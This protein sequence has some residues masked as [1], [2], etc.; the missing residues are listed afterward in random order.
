MEEVFWKQKARNSWLQAGDRNTQHFQAS[1]QERIRRENITEIKDNNGV[2]ITEEAQLKAE[3]VLFFSSLFQA[4]PSSSSKVFLTVIPFVLSPWDNSTL[5]APPTLTETFEP[6]VGEDI[7]KAARYFV[8][9]GQ[10]PRAFSVSLISLVPKNQAAASFADYRPI[11]LC[12]VIYKIFSKLLVTRLSKFLPKLISMEQ[13]AFMQ[14]RSIIENVAMALEAMRNIDK[15]TREGNL[16][17]KLDLEKAYDRVDWVFLKKVMRRFGFSARAGEIASFRSFSMGSLQGSSN[18]HGGSARGTP[19]PQG[20]SFLRL[21]SSPGTLSSWWREAG[22]NLSIKTFLE[23]F[24]DVSGQRIN[25]QKSSFFCPAKM[26]T[27]R[28]RQTERVLGFSK[29]RAGVQYLGIPLYKGRVSMASFKAL[30]DKVEGKKK[31]QWV[32][33]SK[34]SRPIEEGGLGVRKLKEVLKALRRKMA[35]NVKYGQKDSPWVLYIRARHRLDLEEGRTATSSSSASPYWKEVRTELPMLANS[36]Q[37]NVGNGE[38]NVWSTNWTGLGPLQSMVTTHIPQELMSL[39]VKD[40][41]GSSGPCPP[42]SVNLFLSQDLFNFIVHSGFATST[43]P[44]SC[45]WPL[46]SSGQFSSK[47]AWCLGRDLG[48]ENWWNKWIWHSKI[49][50]KMSLFY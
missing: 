20:C 1:A 24:Q 17:V 41:I 8:E 27:G 44:P 10:M 4:D 11:S 12:N 5:L 42:S 30:L 14:G 36:V 50:S 26:S 7:H 2:T 9:G 43:K 49:R 13:G 46:D 29:A 45:F 16:I 18:R 38:L 47:S 31:T 23:A 3:A 21:R 6:T 37:W 48:Q 25:F 35:W 32:A 33:W 15:K 39:Q 22:A 40:F 19:Y 34:I 28:I